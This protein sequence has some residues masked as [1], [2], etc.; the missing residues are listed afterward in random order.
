MV[1]NSTRLLPKRVAFLRALVEH[2]S[3]SCEW[4]KGSGAGRSLHTNS[5]GGCT[6]RTLCYGKGGVAVMPSFTRT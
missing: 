6:R 2:N 5:V 3:K 4:V 1:P